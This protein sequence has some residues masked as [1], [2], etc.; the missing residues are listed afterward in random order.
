MAGD[1]Q[2]TEFVHDDVLEAARIFGGE[3]KIEAQT[4]RARIAAAPARC[5]V[6][7]AP[8][9]SPHAQHGLPAGQQRRDGEPKTGAQKAVDQFASFIGGAVLRQVQEN[10]FAAQAGAVRPSVCDDQRQRTAP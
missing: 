5:H 4:S 3:A 7:H 2:M 6:A 10:G 1:D 9:R 8:A